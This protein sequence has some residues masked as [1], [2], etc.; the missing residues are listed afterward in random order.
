MPGRIHL[1]VRYAL[2]NLRQRP[3]FTATA[4]ITLVSGIGA[5][6]AIFSVANAVLF[7]PLDVPE[8]ER[9]VRVTSAS[10]CLP[11]SPASLPHFNIL[12]EQMGPFDAIAAHRLD[13]L[14][15]TS[16]HTPEQVAVAR[17]TEGFFRI[18]GA[19]LIAGRLFTA[20]DDRPGGARVAVLSAAFWLSRFA[21]DEAAIGQRLTLGG[22]PYLVVGILDRF[23][24]AQFDRAPDVWIPFQIDPQTRDVGGEFCF[25][26]GRLKP[27]ITR[28]RASAE[29]QTVSAGYA[30]RF[31]SRTAPRS[32]FAVSQC[33]KQ[34]WETCAHRWS[35]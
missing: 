2:R 26:T 28:D 27:G 12:R 13:F 6:V 14:N 30:Q 7:R 21:G 34:W 1:D 11:S 10:G 18:F 32:G 3:G 15:F 16:D 4:L 22:Q 9:L 19:W 25:I 8:E 31:P 29:L 33:G 17:V 20:E 5:N 24:P 23:D 35:S